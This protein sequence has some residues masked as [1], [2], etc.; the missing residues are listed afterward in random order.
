MHRMSAW[1]VALLL[2]VNALLVGW[3]GWATCPNRTETGHMAATVYFW[4]T[5]RFDVFHVNPPLTRMVTGLPVSLCR[6]DHDWYFYSSRPQD[7][8]ERALGTAFLKANSPRRM[9]WCFALARWSLIPILLLG[10]YL[11]YRLSCETY[12][13]AA[14]RVFLT[15]WC[16]S[17]LLLSWGATICPDAAAA[18]LGLVA[19]YTFRGWLHKPNWTR[20]AVAGVCLGLLPLTKLT[21]VIAFGLWPVIW[22]LWAAPV[23]LSRADKHSLP[24]PPL[25]HSAAILVIALYVLNIGY[26]VDGTC[27]PLGE[28][29]F[30]SQL[31]HDKE[32]TEDQQWPPA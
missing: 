21:W 5:L 3:I 17:P 11:G 23:W 15:L 31:L 29:V 32:V 16:F 12:G 9:R 7:R 30:M 24:R 20:A 27:R 1:S 8:S 4:H 25:R 26:F 19:V 13:G 14:A 22:C 2:S 6:P 28:Y 18:A 10:G